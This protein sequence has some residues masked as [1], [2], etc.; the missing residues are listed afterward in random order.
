MGMCGKVWSIKN[1]IVKYVLQFT[2]VGVFY[3]MKEVRLRL[4]GNAT[5]TPKLKFEFIHQSPRLGPAKT[6]RRLQASWP[7]IILPL[8]Y[9]PSEAQV[10]IK[11]MSSK[12]FTL[13]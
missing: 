1:C 11:P 13:P 6:L 2:I 9:H 10:P 5:K 3:G 4:P 12:Y 8:P 7:V